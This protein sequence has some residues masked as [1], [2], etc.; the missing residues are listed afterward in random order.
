MANRVRAE[1]FEPRETGQVL[2]MPGSALT[3][4]GVRGTSAGTPAEVEVDC[5]AQHE[6]AAG[7]SVYE[8][9]TNGSRPGGGV[10]RVQGESLGHNEGM[11]WSGVV[12]VELGRS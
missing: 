12:N 7:S 4:A 5:A 8:T 1:L 6:A 2:E 9:R 11:K 10:G 3:T